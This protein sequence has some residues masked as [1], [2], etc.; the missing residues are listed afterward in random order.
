MIKFIKLILLF[1]VISSK[2]FAQ[3]TDT[4]VSEMIQ[5]GIYLY[6]D[7]VG[8]ARSYET[9]DCD[10]FYDAITTVSIFA[11]KRDIPKENID[12]TL[13][14]RLGDDDIDYFVNMYNKEVSTKFITSTKSINIQVN[15]I[16]RYIRF[17]I[18]RMKWKVKYNIVTT[19]SYDPKN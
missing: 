16:R 1:T 8:I 19:Y 15:I 3:N 7:S 18:F 5:D 14:E 9:T 6:F 11:K 12:S 10:C 17:N 13:L 4:Y 2:L